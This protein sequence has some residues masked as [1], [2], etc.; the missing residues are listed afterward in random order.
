MTTRTIKWSSLL[1][2]TELEFIPEPPQKLEI[3]DEL[4]QCLSWL[5]IATRQ[6]RRLVRGTEQGAILVARA[7]EGL[8]SVQTYELYPNPTDDF[9]P[10]V[11]HKAILIATSTQ[12]IK[13]GIIRKF[14]D[15][16][17]YEYYYVPPNSYYFFPYSV[18][19]IVAAYVPAA[20]GT[21]S[22]VGVTTL[23]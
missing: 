17:V 5:T 15:P 4:V 14:V 12:L 7:W 1:N 18:Y 22:Y 3:A 8:N 2:L 16:E 23:I 10:S 9:T 20:G 6:D 19:K 13:V 11:V 21:A